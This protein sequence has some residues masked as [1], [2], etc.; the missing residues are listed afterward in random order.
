MLCVRIA[1]V[2][3][4]AVVWG[5]A[6]IGH[7]LDSEG[8]RVILGASPWNVQSLCGDPAQVSDT[9]EIVLKPVYTFHGVSAG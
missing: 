8:C 4:T 9:I 1:V 2:V 3:L 7:A 5:A 6:G